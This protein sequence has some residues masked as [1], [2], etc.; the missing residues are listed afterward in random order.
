MDLLAQLLLPLKQKHLVA[1]G[2]AKTIA[3]N[4]IY[5]VHNERFI[6]FASDP[7]VTRDAIDALVRQAFILL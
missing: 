1:P 3:A 5:N 4:I 2:C 6:E 7:E